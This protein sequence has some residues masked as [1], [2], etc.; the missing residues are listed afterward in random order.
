MI[1]KIV[2]GMERYMR[3]LG[4][5]DHMQCRCGGVEWISPLPAQ[6]GPSAA[7]KISLS[8]SEASEEV[9]KLIQGIERGEVP[10]LWV[11]SPTSTPENILELLLS[12][13]FKD[14]SDPENPEWGMALKLPEHAPDWPAAP[15]IEVK[16]V[17]SKEEFQLWADI[18]NTALH[19][20]KMID[21]ELYY[22]L[23]QPNKMVFYI[24]WFQG[25][26]AA[27]AATILKDDEASLEFVA[28]LEEFRRRGIGTE[29]C[30][31][32]IAELAKNGAGMVSLRAEPHAFGMYTKLGFRPY[33]EVKVLSYQR[34][35]KAPTAE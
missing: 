21:A 23:V 27:T 10:G 9:D 14:L 15:D 17:R 16:A 33:Y 22:P 5:A 35:A 3:L 30:R 19:G 20:W 6:A 4:E 18:V 32:A 8:G 7:F 34:K 31:F 25:K 13:G 12:K 29:V 28:T 11:P 2:E 26:P 24:G 1:H